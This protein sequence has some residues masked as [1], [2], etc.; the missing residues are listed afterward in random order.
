MGKPD[1]ET[2]GPAY[3]PNMQK[4]LNELYD[5]LGQNPID[6]PDRV[7]GGRLED[8]IEGTLGDIGKYQD[9]YQKLGSSEGQQYLLD[10]ASGYVDSELV[11]NMVD[12]SAS[13][14]G[15]QVAGLNISAAQGGG[16]GS[17]RAGLAQ[18]AASAA[19]TAAL[20]TNLLNYGNEQ[21]D[22]A[23]QDIDKAMTGYG[24][25]IGRD[26]Q[27]LQYLREL[28]QGDKN[29]QWMGDLMESNPALLQGLLYASLANSSP[30]GNVVPS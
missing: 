13:Q 8:A 1:Y 23:A 11:Q 9:A 17:S 12:S 3:D 28:Q 5:S 10:R 2:Q 7:D 21:I 20:N 15:Q 16:V 25:Q 6:M 4:Y 30:L 27:Y 24:D 26:V 14:L 19:S 29:A 18:G 22:R